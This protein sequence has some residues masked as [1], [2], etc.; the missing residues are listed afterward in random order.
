MNVCPDN[1]DSFRTSLM[2]S[3]ARMGLLLLRL[4]NTESDIL[5]YLT[6]GYHSTHHVMSETEKSPSIFMS[7]TVQLRTALYCSVK[8]ISSLAKT[9][10]RL[11]KIYAG[12]GVG[13]LIAYLQCK[14]YVGSSPL[15]K[16]R[17]EGA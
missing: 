16:R 8:L 17:S 6:S 10:K 14:I 1:V 12:H 3:L 11:L 13:T 5:L 4:P 2:S 7:L 15:S 9:V